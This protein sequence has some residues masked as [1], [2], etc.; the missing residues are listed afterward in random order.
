MIS[1]FYITQMDFNSK[2]AHVYN[3]A[4]TCEAL[5]NVSEVKITLVSCYNSLKNNEEKNIFFERHG[6]KKQFKIICLNS[7]SNYFRNSSLKIINWS[8]VILVN[9][10]LIKFLFQKR[11][12]IEVIYFRDH[13]LFL[14]IIFGKYFLRKSIFYENHYVLRKKHGQFL[15]NLLVKISDGIIAISYQLKK[16]YQKLN[17]NIVVCFC[18]AAEH[19]KFDYSKDKLSL[20]KE[21][22]LPLDKF[23]IGYV[24]NLGL[25]GNYDTYQIDK[26]IM[27]LKHLPQNV[28]FLGVGDKN[29]DSK[30]FSDLSAKLGLSERTIFLPWQERTKIPKYLLSIDV[31]FL[32]KRPIDMSGDS[33]LKMFE[34]LATKRPII[35]ANSLAIKEVMIDEVNSLIVKSN[36]PTEWARAI[37][38]IMTDSN[39]SERISNQ[40]FEDSRK[41]T[42][43][44]RGES[45]YSFIDS[46]V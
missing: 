8:K 6:I 36:K 30:P 14:S 27:A 5:A 42:W 19:H 29:G 7:W 44:K 45:I 33:P 20:R 32:P 46:I 31:L 1:I 10:S 12:E 24:G 35:A 26:I 21:L 34:Y 37:E 2:R 43:Q 18:G 39:L 23:I 13:L 41:Y 28:I 3:V 22:N 15:T 40:S 17:K 16:Y 4:K 25:T 11:K 38:R 9:F